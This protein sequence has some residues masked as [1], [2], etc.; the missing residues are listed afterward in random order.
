MSFSKVDST[1]RVLIATTAFGMG[2]DIPNIR[3]IVHWSPPRL[4]ED[5]VQE[6]GRAGREGLT[7]TALLVYGDLH[8]TVSSSMRKYGQNFTTCRKCL[9]A[10]FLFAGSE[11]SAGN[12][13]FVVMF[14]YLV[15]TVVTAVPLTFQ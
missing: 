14:V 9:F 1:L 5:Y 11:D 15:V 4:I 6:T 8:K 7:A 3:W 13:V 10:D 12:D 2:V